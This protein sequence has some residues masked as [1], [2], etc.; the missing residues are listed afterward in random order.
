MLDEPVT[1]ANL[2]E[3]WREA[4]RAAELAE[5]LA[6]IALS[7]AEDAE[8][9]AT[10]SEEIA[11][12]AERAAEA[13]QHAAETARRAAQRSREVATASRSSKLHDADQDVVRA[14][15]AAARAGE[16]YHKA[17]EDARARHEPKP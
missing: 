8:R 17:E 12:M 5:R 16:M 10:A 14:R 13:A 3:A 2:L 1:T 6:A 9:N 7:A 4:T 15:E 11:E